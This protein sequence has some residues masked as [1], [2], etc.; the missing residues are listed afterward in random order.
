M[1]I[2]GE[3]SRKAQPMPVAR[4]VAPG[5]SV[6][7]QSPGAPVMRPVTSAAKPAEPSCAVSTKSTPPWRIASISGS[8]LPLGMPKPRVMPA[9]FNVATIRS[10]LFMALLRRCCIG[11]ALCHTSEA[12]EKVVTVRALEGLAGPSIDEGKSECNAARNRTAARQG[13]H[14]R[15]GRRQPHAGAIERARRLRP[16]QRARPAQSAPLPDL[17]LDRAGIGDAPRIFSCSTST[18]RPSM[19]RTTASCSTAS[20]S[21][22]A[23]STRRAPTSTRWCTAIRRPWCRSP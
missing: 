23:K 15:P 4:L 1:A 11:R 17:A 14:R 8:T 2:S 12:A 3:R 22:T 21:S 9:D 5:P 16:C 18:A 6:A 19:P 13:F 20:V 7:M 10:A